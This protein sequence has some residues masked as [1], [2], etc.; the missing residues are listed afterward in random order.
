MPLSRRPLVYGLIGGMWG[1]ASVAGPLLGGVFTDHVTWRWCFYINLPIGAVAMVIVFFF[2]NVNRN[3]A[4][5]AN[6]TFMERILKLDLYGTAIFIPAIVCLLLALQW[7]GVDYAWNDAKIIGLFCGFGAMIAIFIGIQLWQKDLGTLPP[8][9]F[10]DRNTLAAMMFAMFFGAGFFP[11]IF[12]LCK[13]CHSS[14]GE[15]LETLLYSF[16]S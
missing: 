4:S 6:M 13:L 12:Y 7:G 5:T 8:R 14:P 1:I 3:T 10:K 11:L 2:V 15:I 16:K 9:L